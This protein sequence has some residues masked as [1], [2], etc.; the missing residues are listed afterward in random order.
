LS[1]QVQPHVLQKQQHH[2][3]WLHILIQIRAVS[4]TPDILKISIL[5]LTVVCEPSSVR[6]KYND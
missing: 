5:F 4:G 6:M 1:W 2:V 3:Q